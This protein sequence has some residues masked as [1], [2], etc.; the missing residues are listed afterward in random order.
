MSIVQE[1][2]PAFDPRLIKW[3]GYG[4]VGAGV[5]AGINLFFFRTPLTTTID[6]VLVLA[7]LAVALLWP[8]PFE[9]RRGRGARGF[10]PLFAAPAVGLLFAGLDNQFVNRLPEL[11][12]AIVGAAA[13]AGVAALRATQSGLGSRSQYLFVLGLI[14]AGLG[15]G[16]PATV[17]VAF[18]TAAPQ[19][20]R[21]TLSSEYVT[22]G[23]SV[24]YN[25]R[26]P[27]W[28]PK[29]GPNEVTVSSELYA[30]LDPGDPVCIDLHPGALGV[31]WFVVHACPL[32]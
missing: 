22:R 26:L 31:S 9:I 18:D 2:G 27:A 20:I 4:V 13:L 32:M 19:A 23:R 29:T 16:A 3:G 11:I 8:E 15:L 21:T 25:L 28:G 7:S 24:T 5:A 6:I 17:D 30:K 10:N 14:G 12:G 1:G